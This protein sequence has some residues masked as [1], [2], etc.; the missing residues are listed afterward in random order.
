MSEDQIQQVRTT[1]RGIMGRADA[2]P[3]FRQRAKTDPQGVLREAGLPDDAIAEFA[4]RMSG[5][6][7][8]VAG[9]VQCRYAETGCGCIGDSRELY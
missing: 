8:E 2:D 7:A 3:A 9:Y 5:Q 1:M 6:Q 4:P